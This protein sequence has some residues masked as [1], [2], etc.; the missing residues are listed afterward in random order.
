[1]T[2]VFLVRHG[3]PALPVKK[4]FYGSTDLHLSEKGREQ[5][6]ELAPIWKAIGPL[7]TFSSPLSRALETAR[8]SG[9][10]PEIV[11]ELREID[12]GSWEMVPFEVVSRDFPDDFENRWRD[13]ETFRP[14]GG[15]SFQDVAERATDALNRLIQDNQGPI[16]LFGHGGLFRS[17]LW[18][19]IGIPL[20]VAFRIDH[21]HCGIHVIDFTE[22]KKNLRRTNWL[23]MDRWGD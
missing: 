20:R 4:V 18:R 10:E 21:D 14:P 15:E 6:R 1:M 3:Q 9:L 7:K 2:T 5:A 16:A 23:P 13:I 11:N 8:L 17:I 22:G 12:M 19:T